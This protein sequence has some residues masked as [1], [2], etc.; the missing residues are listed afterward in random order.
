MNLRGGVILFLALVMFDGAV[1]KWALPQSEQLVYIAKDVLLLALLAACLTRQGLRMTPGV[2]GTALAGWLGAYGAVTTLQVLNP[3]L[4]S[5][6]LGLLGLKSHLLYA[7]LLVVVPAAFRDTGALL[8]MLRYL[9]IPVI[10]VLALGVV[11]FYFPID[12]PINRY[13]RG[14]SQDIATFGLLH[15]VRITSTFSYVSGMTVFVFFA[16]CLG[17]ALLAAGRWHLRDAKLGTVC[18]VAAVVVTPMTGARWNFYMAVLCL[19]VFLY[20]MIRSSMLQTRYAWRL[21]VLSFVALAAISFWSIEAIESLQHR[22]QSTFDAPRRVE[23]LLLDPVAF[24]AEAGLLGYGA[25]ATHQ[26]APAL[27]P[28]AGY[29]S[30]LPSTDFE[31][32]PGRIMLEL[33]VVGFV[34]AFALRVYL[35]RLAWLAVVNG[36]TR[37][38]RALAG[39]ALIFFLAHLISPIVFSVTGGALY[40]FLAGVVATILRDQHARRIA[41]GV[42]VREAV[43]VGAPSRAMR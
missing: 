27:V 35:C 14:T 26:A 18:L 33:G 8:Q 20:A 36:G 7:A 39:A 25:G 12:H 34:V 15:H 21:I 6:V 43:L 42:T 31:D 28:D 32:E 30:W 5:V 4:P 22:R 16:T 2:A 29:Y 37:S 24:G 11:Q 19:P 1:R 9:T 13:V 10:A 3:S 17:L 38:E 41:S 40:W 23:S